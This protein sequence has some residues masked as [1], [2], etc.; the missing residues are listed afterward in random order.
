MWPI[1]N[2][3]LGQP[4]A[5]AEPQTPPIGVTLIADGQEQIIIG[6]PMTLAEL[7]AAAGVALGELDRVE[8]SR[9]CQLE[10]IRGSVLDEMVCGGEVARV[11]RVARAQVIREIGIPM[12]TRVR[13][14]RRVHRPIVL[15]EGRPGR[16]LANLE[17]WTRDGQE[18]QRTVISQR[19]IER[20]HPR[21]V[22]RGTMVLPSR[23][24]QVLYMEA[25]AYDPGPRSC[26]RYAS[27]YTAIGLRAGKGV[28]A[29]DPRVIPLG[30]R[31]YVEGYGPCIAGDVGSA[32]KGRRIDLGFG[33]Y[34]EAI[35][36]GRRMVRVHIVD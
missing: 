25:T 35:S 1:T 26:G 24:G 10:Q 31:L 15:R 29:V 18:T 3:S 33:T 6:L 11:V 9:A 5:A 36:F 30:T 12:A 14:D 28:V 2:C 16:A 4:G 27:G 21:V 8:L 13:Y 20:M 7:L 22:L 32:I 19:V 17:I 23:G 34:R